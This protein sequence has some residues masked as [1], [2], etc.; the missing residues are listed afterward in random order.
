MNS[1]NI[2]IKEPRVTAFVNAKGDTLIQMKS[3]DAKIILKDVLEKRTLDSIVDV[4]VE[5]D[6]LSSSTI[7]L[8]LSV[9]KALQEKGD[10]QELMVSNLNKILTNKDTE[11]VLLNDVIKEQ[12]KEIRHQKFLKIVGYITAVVIPIAILIFIK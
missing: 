5:R 4:Y 8:Q 1:Q 9:I 6:K 7:S 12:K 11:I 10:N 2:S 3:S